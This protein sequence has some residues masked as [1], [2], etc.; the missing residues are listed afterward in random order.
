MEYKTTIWFTSDPG[1]ESVGYSG[2]RLLEHSDL[3]IK[4]LRRP[5]ET[6]DALHIENAKIFGGETQDLTIL[7]RNMRMFLVDPPLNPP[8]EP[9]T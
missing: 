1:G 5:V 8:P 9:E 2:N 6:E 7:K 3:E 4:S